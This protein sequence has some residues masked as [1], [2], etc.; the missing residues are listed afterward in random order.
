MAVE[1]VVAGCARRFR[2]SND[3]ARERGKIELVHMLWS[4]RRLHACEQALGNLRRRPVA[5]G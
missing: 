1:A 5:A 4:L 2:L 3:G